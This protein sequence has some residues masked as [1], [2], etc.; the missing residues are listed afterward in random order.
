MKKR[1]VFIMLIIPFFGYSKDWS[2]VINAIAQVESKG[3]TKAI[4]SGNSVGL[5]QIRPILVKDCNLILA[6]MK[7]SK[8]FTL[9]D[10]L[11]P[12]KSK[13][14]FILYQKHYNP[15]NDV[16]KAIRLW[17]GGPNYSVKGTQNYYLKVKKY[18]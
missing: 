14:M 17:N 13:E 2:S 9:E 1:L 6:K 7:S 4:G 11:C 12:K 8:R 15:N 18:L 10:R 16:E 3:N 5:L